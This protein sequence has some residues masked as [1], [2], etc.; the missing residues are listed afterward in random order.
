MRSRVEFS[1]YR[2]AGEPS[3]IGWMGYHDVIYKPMAARSSGNM[4]L[5]VFNTPSYQS[6]IYAFE[7]NVLYAYSFPVYHNRGLRTYVNIRYRFWQK[8]DFWLR[9][10][11]FIYRGVEEVGTGLN[12]ISGNQRSE[13][14]LQLRLQF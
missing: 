10:A 6:S 7:N 9:Y 4:R 12:T 1:Y 13:L 8:M 14:T 11:T 2:K 5:A 3:E